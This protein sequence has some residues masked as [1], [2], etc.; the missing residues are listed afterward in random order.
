MNVF[1][2]NSYRE[3]GLFFKINSFRLTYLSSNPE[4][5]VKIDEYVK[6]FN[7]AKGGCGCNLNKRTK[8]AEE[9]YKKFVPELF[10]SPIPTTEPELPDGRSQLGLSVAIEVKKMLGNPDV[11]HF[12]KDAADVDPFFL[13]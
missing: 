4:F 10:T 12:R 1:N 2:F 6:I 11:I 3:F 9:T 5:Q 7:G 8:V 13:I